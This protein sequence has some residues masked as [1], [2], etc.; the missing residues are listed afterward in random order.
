[1]DTKY[2][3]KIIYTDSSNKSLGGTIDLNFV[4]KSKIIETEDYKIHPAFASGTNNGYINGKWDSERAG[5]WVAKYQLAV[6]GDLLKSVSEKEI[7]NY[8]TVGK[9]MNKD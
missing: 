3:Y 5:F 8:R 7:A 2:E 9:C 1:M 4:S 6:D